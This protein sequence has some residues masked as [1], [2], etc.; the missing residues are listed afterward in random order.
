MPGPEQS[1]IFSCDV[2]HPRSHPEQ[3][4]IGVEY[5][6][7]NII[8]LRGG[9]ISGDDEDGVTY[10]LG[11]SSSGLGISSANFQIDYSYTPFGVFNNVQRFTVSFSM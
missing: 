8:I 11:L 2:T 9:Y 3:L 6:F 1:F 5:K 7:M 4:K 10:G